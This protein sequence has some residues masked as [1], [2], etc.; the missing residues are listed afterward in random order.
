MKE[1]LREDGRHMIHQIIEG[2]MFIKEDKVNLEPTNLGLTLDLAITLL[3]Q[4]S[5]HPMKNENMKTFR[6]KRITSL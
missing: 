3:N 1:T 4:N 6:R 5:I 2:K